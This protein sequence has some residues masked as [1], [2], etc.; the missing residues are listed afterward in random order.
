ML[1]THIHEETKKNRQIIGLFIWNNLLTTLEIDIINP[2][3]TQG[4]LANFG[5]PFTI[6]EN[7]WLLN[8]NKNAIFN[9][10]LFLWLA[11]KFKEFVYLLKHKTQWPQ[12]CIKLTTIE[13]NDSRRLLSKYYLLRCCS[14]SE[15]SKTMS[16]IFVL[17]AKIIFAK[18]LLWLVLLMS[19]KTTVCNIL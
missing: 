13:D 14:F 5:I 3:P 6:I 2:E 1:H 7:L 9:W 4:T 18:L 12:I 15:I 8:H 19:Q 17:H 11:Q 10:N 16:Q